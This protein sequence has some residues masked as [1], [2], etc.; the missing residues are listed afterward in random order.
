LSIWHFL[1]NYNSSAFTLLWGRYNNNWSL[2]HSS[3]GIRHL[4]QFS[5]RNLLITVAFCAFGAAALVN[6]NPWWLAIS[7]SAALFSLVAAGLFAVHRR[8]EKR[9][10]W[11]GYV[12][13]GSLY[14]LLLMYSIQPTSSSNSSVLCLAPLSY[15]NLLTTKLTT[16]TYSH[17]PAALATE[18]LPTPVA[19]TASGSSG[20]PAAGG[21]PGVL[22]GMPGMASGGMSGSSGMPGGGMA[23]GMQGMMPGMPGMAGIPGGMPGGIPPTPNPRF[24]DQMTYTEVGQALWIVLIASLG[25]A[26]SSWLFKSRQRPTP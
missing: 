9:A 15:Q 3:F 10:F 12:V 5:L 13:F 17:L 11:G 23:G 21:M 7:W 24:V 14:V 22:G 1:V 25:G 16:W 20:P 19:P 26:L 4:L 18:Y 8:E 2:S 6:A